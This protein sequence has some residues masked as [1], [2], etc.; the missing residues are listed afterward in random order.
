MLRIKTICYE[1][2]EL[3]EKKTFVQILLRINYLFFE[4][5][6]KRIFI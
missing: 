3:F 1:M 5:K 2:R 6:L 4:I